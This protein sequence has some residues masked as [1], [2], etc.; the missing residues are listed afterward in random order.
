M[1]GV[2]VF[3]RLA[4]RDCKYIT[5]SAV[6]PSEE[7]V[8]SPEALA[9]PLGDFIRAHREDYHVPARC[10]PLTEAFRSIDGQ[11]ARPL[12]LTDSVDNVTARAAGDN[13]LVLAALLES[14]LPGY[15][16]DRITHQAFGDP[17][18]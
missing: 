18:Q 6:L 4:W 14:G 1:F 2:T 17:S 8:V 13:A 3:V 11:N 7:T 15:L 9:A 10:L 12:F 5:H 16:V